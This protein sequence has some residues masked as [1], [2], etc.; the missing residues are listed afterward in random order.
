MI[1][2][3]I[4]SF[5]DT[6]GLLKNTLVPFAQQNTESDDGVP[7]TA[8]EMGFNGQIGNISDPTDNNGVSGIQLKR[9][10]YN[11]YLRK[12]T[13]TVPV[14]VDT[15]STL[16][17]FFIRDYCMNDRRY[18]KDLLNYYQN[19]DVTYEEKGTSQNT[20][21]QHN[22]LVSG[23]WQP[24]T[25]LHDRGKTV[26]GYP[27]VWPGTYIPSWAIDLSS[28]DE[29][30]WT[31]Y[32]V[33][34]NDMFKGFLYATRDFGSDG[35]QEDS[36]TFTAPDLRGMSPALW[37]SDIGKFLASST[38]QHSHVWGSTSVSTNSVIVTHSHSGSWSHDTA[39]QGLH[40]HTCSARMFGTVRELVSD[41][42]SLS[43]KN[44]NQGTL[45]YTS[46]GGSHTHGVTIGSGTEIHTHTA[47]SVT[48]VVNSTPQENYGAVTR[49]NTY[50]VHLIVRV[51]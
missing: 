27:V 24:L 1:F 45:A 6:L 37:A 11:I 49:V 31:D 20:R 8:R 19:G 25:L 10:F 36:E 4:F 15:L 3:D 13:A 41:A 22:Q 48:P 21:F 14:L 39:A 43:G 34:E 12:L 2:K 18:S 33:L 9:S 47:A 38:G 50:P 40:T 32:P 26:L 44:S 42:L 28:H 17:S 7:D 30:S 46:S 16:Y 5:K 29:Y 35:W 51:E 23:Q